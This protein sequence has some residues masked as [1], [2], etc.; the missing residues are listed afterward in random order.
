MFEQCAANAVSLAI[1][2][3]IGVAD[4]INVA[5]RLDAHYPNQRTVRLIDPEGDPGGD[6][7][8]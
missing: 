2:V 4:Q 8:H 7:A 1:R 6:L 3:N 5:H